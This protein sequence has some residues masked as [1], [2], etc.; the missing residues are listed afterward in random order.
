MKGENA[1][2]AG[3]TSCGEKDFG[4]S[5]HTDSGLDSVAAC[6]SQAAVAG[7]KG[8]VPRL[9]FLIR[10]DGSWLY[11]GGEIKRKAMLC[12]F[13]SLL[14]RDAQGAYLLRSPFES[15][16]IEVEDAPFVAVELTWTGVGRTQRLCFRTN[17]DE[18]V[19]ASGEHPIRTEWDVPPEASVDARPP[20]LLV[21][22]GDGR[23]PLE[24]RLSRSVW[25]EL[26]ALAEPGL[27]RGV[28][29]MGVW[30][31]GCFFPLA[32][33]ATSAGAAGDGADCSDWQD[34]TE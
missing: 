1:Q 29:C 25:Y 17:M 23:W 32:R 20:Y 6:L 10:R 26:A 8:D 31:C 3:G 27:H 15:G 5:A 21:R 7:G 30:S 14:T 2:N 22:A 13:G 24:A 11:R 28:R 33:C 16:V 19:T 9:P 12:L 18:T 4:A 34:D